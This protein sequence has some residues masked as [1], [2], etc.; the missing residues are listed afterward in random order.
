M[1]KEQALNIFDAVWNAGTNWVPV[2]LDHTL[3]LAVNALLAQDSENVKMFSKYDAFLECEV[4]EIWHDD[5]DVISFY[6]GTETS[7]FIERLYDK[8]YFVEFD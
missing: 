7:E 1:K 6:Q 5:E 8:G 2:S 4:L 3:E